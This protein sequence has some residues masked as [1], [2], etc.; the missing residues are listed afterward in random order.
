MSEAGKEIILSEALVTHMRSTRDRQ[1]LQDALQDKRPL[2]DL[3]SFFAAFYLYHYQGVRLLHIDAADELRIEE[4]EEMIHKE[5][6]LLEVEVRQLLGEKQREEVDVARLVSEFVVTLTSELRNMNLA[7]PEAI[8]KTI[9]V[10]KKYSQMIPRDYSPNQQIDFITEITGWDSIWRDEAYRKA[11]GLKEASLSLR[12]EMLR[13]HDEE[14]VET[15]VLKQG[16]LSVTGST[17]FLT[18]LPLTDETPDSNWNK[19]AEAVISNLG[20]DSASLKAAADA[21]NLR[22]SVLE[23]LEGDFDTPTSLGEYESRLGQVLGEGLAK[24]IEENPNSTFLLLGHF[25]KMDPTEIQASLRTKGIRTPQELSKGL[26]ASDEG[27]EAQAEGIQVTK[28]ELEE[29]TRSLRTLEKLEHNLE[30]PVKGLLR[31]KGLRSS[32]LEK[33]SLSLLTKDRSKLV[34]I[35]THVIEELEKKMR[36]PQPEEV[37]RL[38]GVRKQVQEG[39]LS[40]MGVSSLSDVSTQLIH[41]ETVAG[42]RLDLVWHL[43]ISFLKNLTRVVETYIRSKQDLLRSKALL[44]SIYEDTE[45]EL[46][47]LREEILIDL[48]SSRL[49]EF[50]MAHPEYQAQE[51]CSWFHARLSNQDFDLAKSQ[52]AATPSPVFEGIA[53]VTLKLDNLTFDNYAIAYDLM[54]RFLQRERGEK[55]AKEEL[56]VD[57]EREKQRLVESKRE[58]LDPL[59]F[60]YTKAHTV[61]RAIG[62]TGT[63]GL[64]W[65]ATDDAKCANLLSFFVIKNRGKLICAVCGT[66]PIDKKC[67][68]HGK[69]QINKSNDIDNIG[70]FVMRSFS[71]I[72]SGLIGSKSEPMT[73]DEAR[74]IV[75]REI[76]HLRR[77]GKLTSKTDLKALMPGEINYNVGPAIASVIG[78]YFNES[79]GY[80]A[81]SADIA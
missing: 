37:A 14:V 49:D 11:S 67:S 79:L 23:V 6:Q 47:F 75:Q 59:S 53:D 54:H 41:G 63:G 5:R 81:R 78:K 19:Y 29:V 16:I 31:S 56:A 60:V 32:E 25:L 61:F 62:R 66:R 18:E 55:L 30:K 58:G 77:R 46:R 1:L 72:K 76:G 73:W 20:G 12:D 71:D 52:L 65:T 42:V 15:S 34:G 26:L 13:E 50:K 70:V 48:L 36:V 10:L 57:V 17:R 27:R 3:F 74:S 80:A 64:G 8:E 45:S 4:Q 21:H 9:G 69:G 33:I 68:L 44:K 38:L 43:T 28:E 7:E 24:V 22:L 40:S 35:E 51:V 39:S 2:E